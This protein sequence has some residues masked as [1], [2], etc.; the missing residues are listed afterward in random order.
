VGGCT[1]D[2]ED[3]FLNFPTEVL[4]YESLGSAYEAEAMLW[5]HGIYIILCRVLPTLAR[6][7]Y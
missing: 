4:G 2:L 5:F 3:Y 1:N 6:R 7:R